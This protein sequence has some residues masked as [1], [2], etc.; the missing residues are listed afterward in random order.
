M[1]HTDQVWVAFAPDRLPQSQRRLNARGRVEAERIAGHCSAVVVKNDR[2]P[3]SRCSTMFVEHPQVQR[4]VDL[5][6][7]TR[8]ASFSGLST[9]AGHTYAR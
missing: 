7:G 5:C 1:P 4:R 9:L 8:G 2:E 3:R 6:G